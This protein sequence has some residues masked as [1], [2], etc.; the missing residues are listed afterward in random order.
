MDEPGTPAN[1][2]DVEFP[3]FSTHETGFCTAST[4]DL[5]ECASRANCA[6]EASGCPPNVENAGMSDLPPRKRPSPEVLVPFVV[7]SGQRVFMLASESNAWV[8]AELQFD[9]ERVAF[10]ETRRS[11]Y[12]WPREAFGA[13]LSRVA[14]RE[15]DDATVNEVAL[16]FGRWLGGQFVAD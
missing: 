16:D 13:L 14:L 4:E 7:Q 12:E 11:V 1:Q 15:V 9:D 2:H 3:Q 10:F 6:V 5:S 8:L